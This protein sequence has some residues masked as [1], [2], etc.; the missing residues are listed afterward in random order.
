[1]KKS[2]S[3]CSALVIA[4][5]IFMAQQVNAQD[6]L[7]SFAGTGAATTVSMVEVENLSTGT[8][9]TLTGS[10]I[11]NLTSSEVGISQP[12][13]INFSSLRIYPNPMMDNAILALSPPEAGEAVITIY[14]V[15]G[16]TVAKIHTTLEKGNQEYRLSGLKKGLYL[17]N[18]T[19][20]TFQYSGKIFCNGQADINPTIEKVSIT[21]EGAVKNPTEKAYHVTGDTNDLHYT[22]GDRLKFKAI[23][24]IYGT[25]KTAIITE[26]TTLTFNFVACTDGDNNSYSVVEI[27]SQ[28]WMAEN[29]KTTKFQNGGIIETTIPD[30][31]DIS[32]EETPKYQWVYK[33][34]NTNLSVYGRLYTWYAVTDSLKLCPVGWHVPENTEWAVLRDFLGGENV[35]GISLKET[36]NDHW[37]YNSNTTNA[38]GFTALAG[39]QRDTNGTFIYILIGSMWWCITDFDTNNAYFEWSLG[40]K[41]NLGMGTWHK[42]YGMSVRCLKDN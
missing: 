31:L 14:E 28:T 7:I 34:D 40:E 5:A 35:A 21:A 11:L 6:Y 41:N 4:S 17:I 8:H 29:L 3:I 15:T 12:G 25:V 36:G 37:K 16:K 32:S 9:I 10:D 42:P 22:A 30:T 27:G 23:S 39:G 13:K 26:D 18:V 20:N 1:M 24:G 38:S 33:S 19:G 2:I